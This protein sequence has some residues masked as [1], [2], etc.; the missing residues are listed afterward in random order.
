MSVNRK[1]K[2]PPIKSLEQTHVERRK[3]KND[4]VHNKYQKFGI[5]TNPEIYYRNN[6]FIIK[7]NKGTFYFYAANLFKLLDFYEWEVYGLPDERVV[8]FICNC[9]DAKDFY[10]NPLN[11]RDE[12]S[13]A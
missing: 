13:E 4:K 8:S 11:V 7:S 6:I 1:Y 10:I 9:K 3:L 5:F 2:K 12:I